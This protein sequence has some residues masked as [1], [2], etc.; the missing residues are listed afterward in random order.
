[1]DQAQNTFSALVSCIF[2]DFAF[3]SFLD[4]HN[5]RGR[6]YQNVCFLHK[7]WI[8]T[9]GNIHWGKRDLKMEQIVHVGT[10][11]VRLIKGQNKLAKVQSWSDHTHKQALQERWWRVL[12][13]SECGVYDLQKQKYSSCN[14][15]VGTLRVGP[16]GHEH[17][18]THRSQLSKTKT[19][20]PKQQVLLSSTEVVRAS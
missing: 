18:Q 19:E 17:T 4:K 16:R 2:H 11:K 7:S 6:Y 3:V 15:A 20:Y 14:T 8:K 12:Q 10:S 1:M 5:N 9:N 13:G